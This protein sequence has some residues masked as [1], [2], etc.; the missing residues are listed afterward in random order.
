MRSGSNNTCA[1]FISSSITKRIYNNNNNTRLTV[2]AISPRLPEMTT[3]GQRARISSTRART[4]TEH[5]GS[6][7][8]RSPVMSF[9]IVAH[10]GSARASS[11]AAEFLQVWRKSHA[12]LGMTS[13]LLMVTVMVTVTG[14]LLTRAGS[15]VNEV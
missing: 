15:G 1:C 14:V 10:S 2:G 5:P 11:D 9:R 6:A 12:G 13:I 7:V 4:G 8:L 3:R